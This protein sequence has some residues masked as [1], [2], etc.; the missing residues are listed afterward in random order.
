MV[1]FKLLQETENTAIYEYDPEN[2]KEVGRVSINK[3]TGEPDIIL[4]SK[5]DRHKIYACKVIKRLIEFQNNNNYE[6]KGIV[7]WY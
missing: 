6:K 1:L 3:Q 2:E 5:N 7:A 4:L